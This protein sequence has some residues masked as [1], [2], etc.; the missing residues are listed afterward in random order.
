[1]A[2]F[3]VD[4][5]TAEL[6]DKFPELTPAS[7]DRLVKGALREIAKRAS[8]GQPV[9]INARL[10]AMKNKGLDFYALYMPA[11]SKVRFGKIYKYER[12]GNSKRKK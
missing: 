3:N 6:Y 8:L 2:Y 1:M 7:I 9:S 10:I 5:I 11:S 4:T 12:S